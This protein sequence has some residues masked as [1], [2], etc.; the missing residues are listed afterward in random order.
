MPLSSLRTV[1]AMIS[2]D[3]LKAKAEASTTIDLDVE[4]FLA[5]GGSIDQCEQDT[6]GKSR[7]RLQKAK[8]SYRLKKKA[9]AKAKNRRMAMI[10]T[11]HRKISG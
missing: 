7:T 10:A 1:V 5:S 6:S 3:I 4:R 8:Q 11:A 9:E 2:T